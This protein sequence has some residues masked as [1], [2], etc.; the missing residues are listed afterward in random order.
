MHRIYQL[1]S[2]SPK[3]NLLSAPKIKTSMVPL[4]PDVSFSSLAEFLKNPD[5]V[6]AKIDPAIRTN[7]HYTLYDTSYSEAE[8]NARPFVSQKLMAFDCDKI[9]VLQDN[10]FDTRYI[11]AFF[12]VTKLDREKT[13][14]VFSGNGLHF[15]I[16][17][18]ETITTPDFFKA[19]RKLYGLVCKR[20][21]K[22]LARQGLDGTYDIDVFD[23]QQTLRLPGT[24][25]VKKD[26]PTRACKVYSPTLLPQPFDLK[27]MAGGEK[28]TK[29]AAPPMGEIFAKDAA[30]KKTKAK[31][32]STEVDPKLIR[33]QKFDKDAVLDGCKFLQH[34]KK[35]AATL[36]EPEWFASLSV[37]ARL[38]G[39]RELAQEYSAGHPGYSEGEVSEKVDFI[40]GSDAGPRTCDN[41]NTLWGKCSTCPNFGVKASPLFIVGEKFI[42]SEDAGFLHI[43]QKGVPVPDYVGLINRFEKDHAY[44]VDEVSEAIFI[45]NGSHYEE[46]NYRK[47]T[48]YAENKF[49]EQQF[50]SVMQEF[51]ARIKRRNLVTNDQFFQDGFINFKNGVLRVSDGVLLPHSPDFRFL[52]VLP[53]DYDPGAKCPEFN[54][55]MT[56]VTRGDKGLEKTLLEYTGYALCERRYWLQ[57]CIIL[58]G[59]GSNG[60]STYLDTVKA[61]CGEGNYTVCSLMDLNDEKHRHSLMGKLINFSE[62]MPSTKIADTENFKKLFGGHMTYRQIYQAGGVF[63][64]TAKLFFACNKLPEAYDP[65]EGYLRRITIVPFDAKFEDGEKDHDILAKVLMELPGIFNRM[66]AAWKDL[67][68]RGSLFEADASIMEKQGYKE[69][70]DTAGMWIRDHITWDIKWDHTSEFID[71]ADIT[72]ECREFL[73]SRN[74]S[75]RVTPQQMSAHLRRIIPDYRARSKRMANGGATNIHGIRWIKKATDNKPYTNGKDHSAPQVSVLDQTLVL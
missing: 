43:N 37:L 42:P 72:A 33:R 44:L 35:N 45:F 15:L 11:D 23:S 36:S 38:P 31:K 22:E 51:F 18:D 70:I 62:E 34:A 40:L 5:A 65:T 57:K 28:T 68:K 19:N 66:Y 7:L 32:T 73:S 14:V 1:R 61:L 6:F 74:P 64:N 26:K 27:F 2:F 58:L 50:E 13:A 16:E 3:T 59:E 41:I 67:K 9:E 71:V 49:K 39:G 48:T 25:N 30:T 55:M 53:F 4:K 20:L 47:I 60:K 46:W 24:M 29:D 56:R 12:N 10:S 63:K 54:D 8:P 17:L 75:Y 21:D 52:S 69:D